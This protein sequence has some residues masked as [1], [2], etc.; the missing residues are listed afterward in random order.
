M[1]PHAAADYQRRARVG[2]RKH[3]PSDVLFGAALGHFLTAFIHDAFLNLAEDG[4]DHR[5]GRDRRVD[6]TFFS[7]GHGGGLALCF[8]F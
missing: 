5:T 3:F 4:R 2:G 6:F 8:R 1:R 7:T